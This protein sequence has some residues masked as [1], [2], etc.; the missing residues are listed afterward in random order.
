LFELSK[1]PLDETQLTKYFEDE[2]SGA[3]VIFIGRVRR[4]NQ[5]REVEFIEYEA[6]EQEARAEFAKILSELH[7][8]YEVREVRCA[9]RI[10][11]LHVGEIAVWI[12]VSSIHRSPAFSACQYI[13]DEIKKRMPIWKKEHYSDGHAE[14]LNAPK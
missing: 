6:A 4:R 2:Q 12:G 3:Y 5:Q 11:K 13:I 9:H 14:W 8:K 10:G 1:N 7:E